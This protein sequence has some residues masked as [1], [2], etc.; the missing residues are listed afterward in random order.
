[1]KKIL[2]IDA[3]PNANSLCTSLALK[4]FNEAKTKG[5][6]VELLILRDL[7]FDP[8]LRSGFVDGQTFEVDLQDAQKKITAADHLVWV[9]PN[10]WGVMP[11][12]LK[13][14]IDRVFLPGWAFQYQKGS[15]LP[16][17]LLVGKTAELIH[18]MD[19]PPFFY[20]WFM[21]SRGI[22]IM[23]SNILEFC[24]IKVTKTKLIGPVRGAQKDQIQNWLSSTN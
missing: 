4:S 2:V 8:I 16:K 12:L 10:W 15:P 14:F 18:T 3:H 17:K 9:Y 22:K 7:K 20:R 1:M 19:T 23:K 11:A 21:G 24:G 5:K 6:E 13:G